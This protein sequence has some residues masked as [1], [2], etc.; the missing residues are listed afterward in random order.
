M[1]I[2]YNFYGFYYQIYQAINFHLSQW[3]RSSAV[4]G[5]RTGTNLV[6]KIPVQAISILYLLE[7]IKRTNTGMG[8]SETH[9]ALD[10]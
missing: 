9:A 5:K 3:L 2:K 6:I 1:E 8:Q 10:I 4:I 7:S